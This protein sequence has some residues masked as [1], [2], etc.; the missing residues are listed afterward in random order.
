MSATIGLTCWHCGKTTLAEVPGNP[1]FAFELAGYANDAGLVGALDM[2]YG[3]ALV[4]CNKEHAD[5]EKTKHGSFRLRPKGP[6]RI[7]T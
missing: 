2:Q 7:A 6:A 4:F 5:A 1:Q 3:R